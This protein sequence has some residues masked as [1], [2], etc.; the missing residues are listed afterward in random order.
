MNGGEKTI[1]AAA[2]LGLCILGGAFL[3]SRSVDQA[4]DQLATMTAALESVKVAVQGSGGGRAAER[5][6]R[7]RGPDPRRIYEI[8]TEGSPAKG[9]ESAAVTLVEFSDFQCP[10]CARVAPTLKAIE[11]EYG[12]KVRLVFKHLPLSMHRKAPAAHAAA[13]A[14]GMQGRF[15]EMHDKIFANQRAMADDKYVEWAA[16]LGLDVE[17]FKADVASQAVKDRVDRDL[18][19]AA[20]LGVSGT[21]TFFV[22]GRYV[23]GAKPFSE[24]KRLIEAQ[25][26]S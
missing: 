9:P 23:S 17:K 11:R 8:D 6:A 2:I 16:E 22:N 4:T 24:F 15:W 18:K 21:P 1:A 13:Q 10:Y 26:K 7:R 12:D 14:A 3:L 19:E 25:L 5:P 20:A